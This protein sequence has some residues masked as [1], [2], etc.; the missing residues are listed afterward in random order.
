ML[1]ENGT[2][3]IQVTTLKP[4]GEERAIIRRVDVILLSV[5]I[6]ME[7]PRPLNLAGP[8]IGSEARRARAPRH[9]EE[10]WKAG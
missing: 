3:R 2:P 8:T 7:I 5:L 6:S 4:K 1:D 10:R 9:G